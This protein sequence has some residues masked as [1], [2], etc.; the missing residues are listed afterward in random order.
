LNVL[1]LRTDFWFGLKAGGSLAHTLGVVGALRSLGH[2]V[3]LLS[4]DVLPAGDVAVRV[5]APWKPLRLPRARAL[6]P[7]FYNL[8]VVRAARRLPG[9]PPDVI[10]QRHSFLSCA[11][12]LLSQRLRRPLVMEVNN[13]VVPWAHEMGHRL[14]LAPLAQRVERRALGRASVLSAVSG[15]VRDQL[16][17]DGY[18]PERTIVN[19]N[20]V[21]E[22]KFKPDLDAAGLRHSLGLLGRRVV[23]FIGTFGQWHGVPEL[24]RAAAIVLTRRPEARFLMVGDGDQRAEAERL[25]G[26]A[27][28]AGAVVFTGLV[29]QADAAHHLAAC[30]ILVS[31][32]VRPRHG[33]FIGS[34]TKLFEYMA[35]GR[36]IV[37]SDLDQ[38]GEILTHEQN[39]LLV[40]PND[41]AALADAIVRL[42]DDAALARTL[43]AEARRVVTQRYTWRHNVER[44]LDALGRGAA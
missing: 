5:V 16:A 34:P 22:E 28:V 19:P 25:I 42:I 2:S 9:S 11:G 32:H 40:P 44:V 18:P 29:P 26:A 38:I 8:Q 35:M 36:A 33:R 39:A 3:T 6:G 17:A 15:V 1:Y 37:A 27:G 7:L 43:G 4:S 23:G 20:G 21:D 30:D 24:A 14:R 31:P 12:A 13:L 10:Y 41:V